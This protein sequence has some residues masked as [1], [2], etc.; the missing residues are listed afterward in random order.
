MILY[1]STV[2]GNCYKVR[3]L[4]ARLGLEVELRDV[5]VVSRSRRDCS[6]SSTS[7]SRRSR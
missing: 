6:S 3:L 2:S 5:D 7:T 4:L 1:N